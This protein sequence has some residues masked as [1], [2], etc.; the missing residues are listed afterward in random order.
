[1][2]LVGG[3]LEDLAFLALIELKRVLLDHLGL[4]QGPLRS[5][6]VLELFG[7]LLSRIQHACALLGLLEPRGGPLGLLGGVCVRPAH[8]WGFLSLLDP[9]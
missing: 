1:M 2:G 9:S 3:I 7:A 5:L 6:G 4:S 8:C